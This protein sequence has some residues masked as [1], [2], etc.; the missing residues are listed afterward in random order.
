MNHPSHHELVSWGRF[1]VRV[2]EVPPCSEKG[3]T[4]D[5]LEYMVFL[6]SL[7]YA[8]IGWTMQSR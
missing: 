1:V 5:D 7:G 3:N 6:R 2:V 4:L 8:E